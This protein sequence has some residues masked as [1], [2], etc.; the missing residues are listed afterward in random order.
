MITM[1]IQP[2]EIR[3]NITYGYLKLENIHHDAA[4]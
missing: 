1:Q 2:A 4:T 3:D